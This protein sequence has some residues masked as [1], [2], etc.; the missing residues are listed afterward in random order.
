MADYEVQSG[1]FN[2]FTG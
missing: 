2:R 1:S